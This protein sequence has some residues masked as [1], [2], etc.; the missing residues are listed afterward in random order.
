MLKTHDPTHLL[1]LLLGGSMLL[2]YGVKQVTSAMERACG[3]RL[4]LVVMALANRPLAAFGAGLG[5]TIL[6]QSSTAT[7]SIMIGLV[8]TQLVPLAAAVVMLLGA[9]V[10]S[11]LVVQLLAF[12]F[13]D[14]ALEFLGLAATFA[15]LARRTQWNEV[16]RGLVSFGF[17]LVGLAMIDAS[18]T[19]IAKS[20]I[21]NAIL[22]TLAQSPL[23]LVLL[24]VLLAAVFVSSIAAIGIVMVLAAAGTLPLTAALAV[25]LGAN[26]G[27]TLAPLV[28]ALTQGNRAGCRLGMIYTGT[29]LIGAVIGMVLIT[30]IAPILTYLLPNPATQIALAHCGFNIILAVLF[31]PFAQQLAS[32]ATQ[33]LPEVERA[34]KKGCRYLDPEALT[35]PAVA[36]GQAMREVLRMADLATEMLQLS[37]QAFEEGE[38]RLPKRIGDLDDQLDELETAIKNYLIQLNDETLSEE[39]AQRELSLLHI[40]TELEAIGDIVDRQLMRLARRK[41]RK[42]IAFAPSAWDDIVAYHREVLGLLQQVLAGLAT[43]DP[44]IA[45][46]VLAQRQDINQIKRDIYLRHLQSLTS[47]RPTNLDASAIHLE[48]VN[49]MSRILSHT[50]SIARAV[51]GDL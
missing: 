50:C 34:K 2:L 23:V 20:A 30:P 8:N 35:L 24:G 9:A 46:E 33:L 6:T 32:F 48:I 4:Q 41:R 7:A 1:I 21:T 15:L 17:V 49:A 37:I 43:Q 44:E 51:Q 36:L 29:R 25:T 5:I 47:G 42:Q 40:S 38:K 16:G 45:D 12:H 22:Q 19:P 27:T 13:T 3:A 31:L 14:Y 10:G 26:L 39:Q 11:T 18:S 28:S